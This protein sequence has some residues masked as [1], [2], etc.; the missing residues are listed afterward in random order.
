M[1]EYFGSGN[2]LFEYIP[3]W[4]KLPAGWNF[5]ECPGVAIDSQDNV[6]VLTR[7]Q[8]PIIVFNREGDFLRSF[9]E[10]L[11]TDRTHGLAITH[12]DSLLAAV[13]YTHL[14]LPT[15]PYV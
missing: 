4:A 15:T 13:S 7:G 14:T 5:V 8:H 10:G 3:N 6:Y 2:F 11:F 9:G 12:D 1:S